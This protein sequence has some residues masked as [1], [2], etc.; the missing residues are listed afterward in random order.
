MTNMIKKS[1][2]N[3]PR[4][5]LHINMFNEMVI[6]KGI[7]DIKL[8]NRPFVGHYKRKHNMDIGG[9]DNRT[10][11][12]SVVK[13]KYMRVAFDNEASFETL[14]G[15]IKKIFSPK[16]LFRAHNVGVVSRSRN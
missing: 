6:E 2:I 12:V 10:K 9:L 1:K 13:A 8:S 14:N 15:A 11:G 7:V 5:L 4:G 16:N 3:I